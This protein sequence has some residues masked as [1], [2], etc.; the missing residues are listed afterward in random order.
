M[1]QDMERD[2]SLY[3][4]GMARTNVQLGRLGTMHQATPGCSKLILKPEILETGRGGSRAKTAQALCFLLGITATDSRTTG[5]TPFNTLEEI[6]NKPSTMSDME[7]DTRL[8][9]ITED[10]GYD[11]ES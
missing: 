2:G 11:T 3:D 4:R 6:F 9:T 10:S 5:S 1:F 8:Q 7:V